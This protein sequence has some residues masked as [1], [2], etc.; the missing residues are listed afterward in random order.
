MKGN[1]R[2]SSRNTAPSEFVLRVCC[3]SVLLTKTAHRTKVGYWKKESRDPYYHQPSISL[4]EMAEQI[5][6]GRCSS[7]IDEEPKEKVNC[8]INSR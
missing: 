4:A 7:H 5:K 8:W 3:C 6:S 2:L 1:W